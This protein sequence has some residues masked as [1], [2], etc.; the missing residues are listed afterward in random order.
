MIYFGTLV[1][2]SRMCMR[3]ARTTLLSSSSKS[4]VRNTAAAINLQVAEFSSRRGGGRRRGRAGSDGSSI[5]KTP[6]PPANAADPWVEVKDER[7]QIYYWN[8]ETD[9]TTAVGEPRPTGM[10]AAQ[11]P[12]GGAMAGFAGMVAQGMAFGTGSSLAHHAIGSLFGGGD[13][14]GGSDDASGGDDGSWDI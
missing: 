5:A 9:E 1:Q 2:T 12:Q 7:G 14:S 4:M 11:A 6:P 13:D 8:T 10:T 3:A